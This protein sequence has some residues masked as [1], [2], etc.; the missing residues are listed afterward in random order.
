MDTLVHEFYNKNEVNKEHTCISIISSLSLFI[1]FS[2]SL[3]PSYISRRLGLF[4]DL[5]TNWE[6]GREKRR[7]L[8]ACNRGLAE[9]FLDANATVILSLSPHPPLSLSLSGSLH[10]PTVLLVT[11]PRDSR[12]SPHLHKAI[13]ERVLSSASDWSQS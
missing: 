3:F 5:K 10:H 9:N 8:H 11:D 2:L 13:S 1:S 7:R 6:K 4:N 12:D